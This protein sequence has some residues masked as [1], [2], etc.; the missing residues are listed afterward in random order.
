MKE[1]F[2]VTK[3]G[4]MDWELAS[5]L[6]PERI[7]RHVAI[8]M[9]GNGRWARKRRLPRVA[10]HKAGIA[11]VRES[12]DTCAR[13][14]VQWLTLYASSY[15]NVPPAIVVDITR[16]FE[17][18][19]E[20]LLAYKS[21]Y[22]ASS[23]GSDLFPAENEIRERLEMTARFYGNLIGVKYGEPYALKEPISIDDVMDLGPKSF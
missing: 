7:P 2:E 3:P 10:G 5:G 12:V 9:D 11:S 16:Q 21:Q 17:R 6:D 14:G 18:R 19:M 13:L 4:E 8:I 15:A 23:S 1:I 20:A 22:G